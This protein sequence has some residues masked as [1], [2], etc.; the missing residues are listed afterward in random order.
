MK[1]LFNKS[2]IASALMAASA[3]SGQV[4]AEDELVLYTIIDGQLKGAGLT[5]R[6]N[7]QQNKEINR[8]GVASFDLELGENLVE[9]LLEDR[10]IFVLPLKAQPGENLDLGLLINPGEEI[11]VA[12]D[13][14]EPDVKVDEPDPST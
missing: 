2:L 11:K 14:Y 13:R 12:V 6:I 5:A 1:K 8:S 9:V 10:I 7:G 4:F 3:L